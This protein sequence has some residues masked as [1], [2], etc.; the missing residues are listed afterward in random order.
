MNDASRIALFAVMAVISY[1]IGNI[2]PATLVGRM[3]GVDIRKEGSGNPGTTNVLRTLGAKAAACTLLIDV[4]KG[5]LPVLA[6]R[7]AGGDLLACICG[8]AA[9]CGH[10]WPVV[11][12]FKGG[13]GIA[14]G[15]GVLIAFHWQV[16][17][18]CM[19][20]ALGGA[21]IT[22]R[23]SVGSITA[24]LAL[25]VSMFFIDRAYLVWSVCLMAIVLW[26]HR[27]N[28]VRIIHG[29]EPKMSF[30]KKKEPEAEKEDAGDE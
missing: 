7:F 3:H 14:T 29:Q 4:L 23:M 22:R 16:G 2:S 8:T 19:V 9:F 28:I 1:F 30:S 10:I 18:V 11:F 6:G 25:P 20:F 17:L 15:F 5:L 12:R 13:K 21:A 26:R 27:S 24:A